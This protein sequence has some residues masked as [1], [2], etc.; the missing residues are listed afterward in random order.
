MDKRLGQIVSEGLREF[1]EDLKS[2]API[3]TKYNLR[4]VIVDLEPQHYEA[5]D[6]Q[7]IRKLLD[8]SQSVFARLLGVSVK[9]VQKWE[10]GEQTP[11][12]IAARFMDE[13]AADPEHFR[14]RLCESVH[15]K[16]A[17]AK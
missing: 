11:K 4:R 3:S 5:E 13:I 17:V 7:R 6:V 12:D 9:A 14:K 16:D 1:T 2:S 10:Q 8:A 15:V